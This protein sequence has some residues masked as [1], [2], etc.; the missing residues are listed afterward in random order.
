MKKIFISVLI[1]CGMFHSFGSDLQTTIARGIGNSTDAA[2]KDALNQA[3]MQAAGAIVDSHTLVKNDE[4]IQEKVL[5]ASNAIVKTYD[6]IMPAPKRSNGLFEIRIK[7]IVQKNLLRQT[8]VKHSII[9]GNV[10]G[11]Q[12]LWAEII[13]SEKNQVDMNAMIENTIK[14]TNFNKYLQFSLI[15][16]NGTRGNNTRLYVKP[17]PHNNRKIQISAGL[18]CIFDSVRFQRECMPHLKKI[19]DSLPFAPKEEFLNQTQTDWLNF[20]LPPHSAWN[21]PRT[22]PVPSRDKARL[23]QQGYE[24]AAT[25]RVTPL[26]TWNGAL[27]IHRNCRIRDGRTKIFLNISPK[28]RPGSQR[29]VCYVYPGQN[30]LWDIIKTKQAELRRLAV[31]LCLLD[32]DDHTTI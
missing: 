8:F 17:N 20:V 2:L 19:F 22:Q 32:K 3:I 16:V 25:W 13:T 10:E 28:Y 31:S 30:T 26:Y 9:K 15:G 5:T 7:A 29:F 24:I 1:L 23:Q 11:A 27:I 14:K 21:R 12:N 6:V 18:I 4:I